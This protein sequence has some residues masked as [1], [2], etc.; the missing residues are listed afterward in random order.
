[1]STEPMPRDPAP[2]A[3]KNDFQFAAKNE[4]PVSLPCHLHQIPHC[5]V[6][7]LDP[8]LPTDAKTSTRLGITSSGPGGLDRSSTLAEGIQVCCAR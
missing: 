6:P 2:A 1:M 5:F 7:C 4:Q 3:I 8:C